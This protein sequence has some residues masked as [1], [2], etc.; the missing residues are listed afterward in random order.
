[1]LVYTSVGMLL[2]QE[3]PTR[4]PVAAPV[5]GGGQSQSKSRLHTTSKHGAAASNAILSEQTVVDAGRARNLAGLP[6]TG[7][8]N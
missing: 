7:R 1:M 4:V 3:R 2:A 8:C 5:N 6:R